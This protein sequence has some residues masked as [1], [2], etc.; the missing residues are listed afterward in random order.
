MNSEECSLNCCKSLPDRCRWVIK[1]T[2]ALFTAV[3]KPAFTADV[4][5]SKLFNCNY[6]WRVVNYCT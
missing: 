5:G 3:L 1:E 4:Y 6:R 2:A